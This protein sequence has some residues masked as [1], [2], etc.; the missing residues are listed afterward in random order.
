MATLVRPHGRLTLPFDLSRF[1]RSLAIPASPLVTSWADLVRAAITVGK[2]QTHVGRYGRYSL[3]EAEHRT[4]MVYAYLRSQRSILRRSSAYHDLDPSEKSGVSYMHGLACA[5]LFAEALDV[6]WLMHVDRYRRRYGIKFWGR[7]RP[8]LFGQD[9]RG[10]WIVVEAKGRTN[11]AGA[12]LIRRIHS[13][14]SSIR[15]IAGLPPWLSIGSVSHFSGGSLALTVVDPEEHET[16]AEDIEIDDA[17]FAAAYYEPIV[18]LVGRE[19]QQTETRA[20]PALTVDLEA[21]DAR[22]GLL[23]EVYE[24]ANRGEAEAIL[25]PERRERVAGAIDEDTGRQSVGSDGVVVKLGESWQP[26]LMELN[27]VDRE[28]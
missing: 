9:G 12:D 16:D 23:T 22:I 1:P 18:E 15:S 10:R 6:P 28:L 5:K 17:A 8:D 25:G 7:S 20:G 27:P 13:Q 3:F 24:I 4:F 14:K 2:W 21:V 11:N 26:D 19:R